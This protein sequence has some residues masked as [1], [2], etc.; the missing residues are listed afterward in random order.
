[1]ADASGHTPAA[2]CAHRAW[3]ERSKAHATAE[4]LES[5]ANRLSGRVENATYRG[6]TYGKLHKSWA[7]ECHEKVQQDPARRLERHRFQHAY[8]QHRL[9]RQGG[10]RAHDVLHGNGIPRA[11]IHEARHRAGDEDG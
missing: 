5:R 6:T 3:E 8:A 4:V 9:P 7:A 2:T 11:G 10:G 1:M